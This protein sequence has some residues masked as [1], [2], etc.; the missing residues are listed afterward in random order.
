M[1]RAPK[2]PWRLLVHD[3]DTLGIS[4]REALMLLLGLYGAH[5]NDPSVPI[6][7]ARSLAAKIAAVH[8]G[9]STRSAEQKLGRVWRI[10]R[11]LLIAAGYSPIP[12]GI[13]YAKRWAGD[14]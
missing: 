6:P 11:L 4:E 12:R 8:T 7:I 2:R 13:N 14:A 1:A 10:Y 3:I 9:V 5:M